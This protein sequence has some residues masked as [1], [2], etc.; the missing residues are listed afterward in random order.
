MIVISPFLQVSGLNYSIKL[1]K[2]TGQIK[3]YY[4]NIFCLQEINFKFKDT[5]RLKVKE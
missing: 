2:W 1:Q 3:T 4:P 5:N